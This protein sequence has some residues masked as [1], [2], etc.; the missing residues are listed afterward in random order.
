MPNLCRPRYPWVIALLVLQIFAGN[1]AAILAH[2]YVFAW[3]LLSVFV[4]LC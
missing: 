3:L 2:R 4:F 1:I